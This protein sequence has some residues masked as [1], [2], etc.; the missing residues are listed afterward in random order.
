M[1]NPYDRPKPLPQGDE[2][3]DKIFLEIGKAVS[4]WEKLETRLA[5]IYGSLVSCL[6]LS[7]SSL[8][9]I[10]GYSTLG[11]FAARSALVNK[12]IEA[13]FL[14]FENDQ[15]KGDLADFVSKKAAKFNSRRNDIV[16]GTCV[17]HASGP[18]IGYYW[19]P[20]KHDSKKRKNMPPFGGDYS[21]T[22]TQ[23]SYFREQFEA[24]VSESYDLEVRIMNHLSSLKS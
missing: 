23:I 9:A 1:N 21:L 16:H 18:Q 15:L 4:V 12:T 8:V 17:E 20:P 5:L 3:P 2:T 6:F 24:L 11:S 22:S 7:N 13:H 19:E 14:I 10:Q